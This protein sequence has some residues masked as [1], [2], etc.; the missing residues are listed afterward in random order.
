MD[1]LDRSEMKTNQNKP[2]R[3]KKKKQV[4]YVRRQWPASPEDGGF[5]VIQT[6]KSLPQELL[7]GITVPGNE[8]QTDY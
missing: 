1:S 7:R 3:R 4:V 5:V 8:T 6:N 2:K